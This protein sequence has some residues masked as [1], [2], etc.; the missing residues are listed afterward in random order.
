MSPPAPSVHP[1]TPTLSDLDL[2][3][4]NIERGLW[5]H[6]GAKETEIRDQVDM[7]AT[8]YYQRLNAMLDR[9]DVLAHDPLLVKRLRRIRDQRRRT[10]AP[11][12]AGR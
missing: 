11:V 4:L 5:L 7:S 2:S 1:M 12:R 9:E 10:R 8:A 3:I 6:A